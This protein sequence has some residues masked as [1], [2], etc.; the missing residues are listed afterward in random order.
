MIKV[1]IVEDSPV[2][3]DFLEHVLS[4]DPAIRVVGKVSDGADALQAVRDKR[5]DVITMDIHMPKMDGFE[6]TRVIMSNEPRPIVVVSASTGA[7]DIA[8]TFQAIEAGALAVVL[9]P[10]GYGHPDHEAAV[11]EL[12]RTVKMMSEIRVVRQFERPMKPKSAS[13][14]TV[15]MPALDSEYQAGCHRRFHGRAS[16]PQHDPLGPG[17]GPAGT[18]DHCPTHRSRF[19]RGFRR[20]AQRGIGLS[21]AYRLARSEASGRAWVSFAGRIPHRGGRRPEHRAQQPCPRG[22][23]AALRGLPVSHG[24]RSPRPKLRGRAADRHGARWGRPA[25]RNERQGRHHDRAGQRQ[26]DR[27]RHAGRGHQIGR[28]NARPAAGGRSRPCWRSWREETRCRHRE[29]RHEPRQGGD[30]RA[31]RRGQP[32]AG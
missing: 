30:E 19:Y 10:P 1:L 27:A 13:V 21:G 20:M 31:G 29:R 4:S 25:Q 26:F 9:R 8:S 7:K 2:V 3:Q 15:P 11:R 23:A 32:H 16:G 22:R 28:G 14:P 6:A 12:V 18:V 5:P 17:A 24:R